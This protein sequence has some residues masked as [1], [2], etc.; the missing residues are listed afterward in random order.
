MI[1]LE[2]NFWNYLFDKHPILEFCG[3]LLIP[4]RFLPILDELYNEI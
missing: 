1:L 4:G 3:L 2:S